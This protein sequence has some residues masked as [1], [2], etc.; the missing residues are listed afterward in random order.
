MQSGRRR[1]FPLM[2]F[3]R[4]MLAWMVERTAALACFTSV[5][6]KAWSSRV[7]RSSGSASMDDV[8]KRGEEK[9]RGV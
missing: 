1:I 8:E 6:M 5:S 3:H 7:C 2:A 9:R 4:S